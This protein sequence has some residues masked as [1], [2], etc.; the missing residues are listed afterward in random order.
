MSELLAYASLGLHHIAD[1]SGADHMLFLVAL[2]VIYR[3]RDWRAAAWVVTA[4]TAGHSLTL[5]LAVSG[6]VTLPLAW[7]EFLIPVTIICTCG[8]NLWA[9]RRRSTSSPPRARAIWALAFGLVHGAGFATFLRSL[10]L[11]DLA[12]PLLGFN[13]GIEIG[14]LGIL[15]LAGVLFAGLDAA[16]ARV[17]HGLTGLAAHRLRLASISLVVL[18]VATRIAF[19]RSPW[20]W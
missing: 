11:D 20:T 5:G 9:A 16:L 17:H 19:E 4:F 18:L 6:V 3:W 14:Q 13:L 1:L 15:L 12:V 8:E 10:F 2:A 7:I